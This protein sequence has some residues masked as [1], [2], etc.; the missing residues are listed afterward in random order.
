MISTLPDEVRNARNACLVAK[1]VITPDKHKCQLILLDDVGYNT[2]ALR[3]SE[4]L[5]IK[6]VGWV[7][8]A[9]AD[10]LTAN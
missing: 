6:S 1:Q 4:P 5:C 2:R 7:A 3:R 8:L 10:L 9:K